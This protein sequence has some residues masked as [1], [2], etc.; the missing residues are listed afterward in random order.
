MA[1]LKELHQIREKI[2]ELKARIEHERGRGLTAEQIKALVEERV[3][4]WGQRVFD[5]GYVG[6]NLAHHHLD[7]GMLAR[8]A[9]VEGEDKMVS[10]LAWL[11]P[12][13]MKKRLTE[14]AAPFAD[15]G[16]AKLDIQKLERDCYQLERQEETV[17]CQLEESG[18]NP[19]PRRLDADPLIFLT[20]D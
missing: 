4:G 9:A 19:G 5:A 17:Y 20:T 8:A 2:A 16:R 11:F 12:D 10:V 1:S 6:V 3:D 15:D 7:T 14:C 13:Q 18:V